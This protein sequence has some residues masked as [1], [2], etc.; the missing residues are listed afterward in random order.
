[1]RGFLIGGCMKLSDLS[2]E[3]RLELLQSLSLEVDHT[4]QSEYTGG[5]DGSGQLYK[6][7][8][9]IK[10]RLVADIDEDRHIISEEEISL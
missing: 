3:D 6:D 7:Y 9:V 4:T 5:M 8:H 2:S 10:M 1:M